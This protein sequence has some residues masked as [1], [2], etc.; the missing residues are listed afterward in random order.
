MH[1]TATDDDGRTRDIVVL[2]AFA[3]N[4]GVLAAGHQ[5]SEDMVRRAFEAQMRK[6]RTGTG[7]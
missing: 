6:V 4:H 7:L 3:G 5:L 2:Q 1:V